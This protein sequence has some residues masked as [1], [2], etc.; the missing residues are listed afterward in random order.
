MKYELFLII[1]ITDLIIPFI[2]A[3]PYKGYSHKKTVMSVLG[4]K[5]SPLGTI[6]NIWMLISGI[7]ISIFGY[8]IFTYYRNTNF[9]LAFTTFILLLLYGV[10]DEIISGF[11]PLNENKA[12]ITFSSRIHGIGSVIGF[13][14]L[15]FAPLFLAILEFKSGEFP[16]GLTSSV[17]FLLSLIAFIF[18]IAGENPKFQN[19]LFALEG[20][21]QRVLLLFMYIPFIL[22]LMVKY[23]NLFQL[24]Y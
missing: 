14:A 13:I 22:W 5:K 20:L 3:I 23:N 1:L 21:W 9:E 12:N 2:I 24:L 17:F 19:T 10:S 6:Y 7:I 8:H 18:F 4:C 11:F 15:Q 16:L